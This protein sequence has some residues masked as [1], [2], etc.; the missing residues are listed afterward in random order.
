MKRAEQPPAPR[1]PR[2]VRVINVGL[3]LFADALRDQGASVVGVD[4]RVPAGGDSRLVAAL[5]RL[6]GP[7]AAR[8]DAANAQALAHLRASPIVRSVERAGSVIEGLGERTLLHCGPPISWDDMIDPLRRSAT[9]AIVAEGWAD[10]IAAAM[11]LVRAGEIE[12]QPANDHRAVVPMATVI[13]PSAP[14]YVVE[15][16]HGGTTAFSSINQG[17]GDAPWFGVNSD[18]AIERLKLVRDVVGPV[19]AEALKRHGG[20]EI[21]DLAA[22]GIAMADDVHMRIQA[23]TNLLL[24]DLLP[25]L[26][27]S[28]HPLVAVAAD[29]LSGN[30][31]TTLNMA[32]AAAKSLVDAAAGVDGASLVTTMARNGASFGVRLGNR[33]WIVTEAPPVR[34]ALFRP[35]FGPENAAPDI[36]DSAVLEL[37]GLGASIAGNTPA[38]ATFLGGQAEAL[39]LTQAMETISAGESDRFRMPYLSNKGSPLGLDVRRMAELSIT[40]GI[41]TGIVHATD[42]LGQIGAGIARAPLACFVQAALELDERIA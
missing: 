9:A 28:S 41:S 5:E 7:K 10:D 29:F 17:A 3:P 22:Q 21:L 19:L 25:A 33:P 36:G 1:L 32:M 23:T 18:A 27:R 13:G 20:I 42:G 38:A 12:F 34:S 30:P 8:I 40:P 14:V 2:E 35:G 6:L 16:A 15:N 11:A 39:A 31:L 4:W 24:R 37:I 26:V